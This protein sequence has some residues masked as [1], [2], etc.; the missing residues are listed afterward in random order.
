LRIRSLVRS[1]CSDEIVRKS[2]VATATGATMLSLPNVSACSTF[3]SKLSCV[4]P[5]INPGLNVSSSSPC[6]SS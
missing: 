5:A 2:P 4:L 6:S 1:S 3:G